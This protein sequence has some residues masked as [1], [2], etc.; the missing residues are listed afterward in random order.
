MIVFIGEELALYTPQTES[1]PRCVLVKFYLVCGG[2]CA[3]LAKW[4]S[5]TETSQSE[6]L[7]CLPSGL[8]QEDLLI[9]MFFLSTV[10]A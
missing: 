9:R 1:H 5:L 10:M 7:I 8:L 4:S 3:A 6:S 2:F